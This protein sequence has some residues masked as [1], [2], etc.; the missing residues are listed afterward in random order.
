MLSASALRPGMVIRL[1]GTPYKVVAADYHA[2]GGKMGGVTHAKLRNLR[3]GTLREW[4]F[5]ADEV[6]EPVELERRPMQF[7]YRDGNMAHF[8][9]PETY[10][11]VAVD[12]DAL[13]RAAD[14]LAEGMTLPV[15]LLDGE[16]AGVVFPDVVEAR[17]EE[18]APPV[19]SQ[20][21]D[22]VWKEAKLENGATIRVPP[23]I[24]PGEWIRVD[25]QAGAY[26]ER[27]KGKR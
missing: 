12:D 26:V 1:E 4:R 16:P 27:A 2:G 21:T 15:E 24:A 3:T 5:R 13:G 8:M 20:G 17:V 25:V 7:L 18:T 14:Y 9:N 23:F 22:N 19:H 10:E 6:L 11:Q